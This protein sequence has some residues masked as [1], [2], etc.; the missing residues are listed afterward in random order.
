MKTWLLSA[1]VFTTRSRRDVKKK[2]IQLHSQLSF[3]HLRHLVRG[4][5]HRDCEKKV[6]KSHGATQCCGR[7]A[8]STPVHSAASSFLQV[9]SNDVNNEETGWLVFG[10]LRYKSGVCCML[11]WDRVSCMLL[12]QLFWL[13]KYANSWL[14]NGAGQKRACE[15]VR[16]NVCSSKHAWPSPHQSP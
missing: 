5:Q 9:T 7:D 8:D 10:V 13:Q 15:R 1:Q 16:A 4:C 12:V 3:G 14:L 2:K 11:S 6:Q